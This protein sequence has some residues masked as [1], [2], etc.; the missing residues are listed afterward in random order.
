MHEPTQAQHLEGSEVI[1]VETA[2]LVDVTAMLRDG[3]I[4]HALV[5]AAFGH[6]AFRLH[7]LGLP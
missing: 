6:L 2:P 5:V 1:D 3:R 7:E 4:S